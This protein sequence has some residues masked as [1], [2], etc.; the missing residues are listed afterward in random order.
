MLEVDSCAD[1]ARVLLQIVQEEGR[2]GDPKGEDCHVPLVELDDVV[3]FLHGGEEQTG[4]ELG[5]GVVMGVA[6]GEKKDI[7]RDWL[8]RRGPLGEH[9]G[10]YDVEKT[11]ELVVLENEHLV[12]EAAV[13]NKLLTFF[14]FPFLR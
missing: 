13:P 6:G 8:L 14:L 7:S 1:K 12:I 11:V 4:E 5:G 3:D 9:V 2:V 10:D